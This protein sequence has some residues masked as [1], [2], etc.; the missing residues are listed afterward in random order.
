MTKKLI[1]EEPMER[2]IKITDVVFELLKDI[3]KKSETY[4][5][6]IERM[7]TEANYEIKPEYIKRAEEY[8]KSRRQKKD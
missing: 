1:R 2:T 3:G 5:Q 8:A 4:S 6:V 7:A